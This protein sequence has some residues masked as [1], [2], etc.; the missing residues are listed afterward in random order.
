[1]AI[2]QTITAL[3]TAPARTQSSADFITNADAFVAALGTMVTQENTWAGQV[4]TV[5]GE[6]NNNAVSA[7]ADA[8]S[9]AASAST[10][11][12]VAG[13]VAWVSGTTYALNDAAISQIDFQT[14]RRII[15]GAGTTDPSADATNWTLLGG[16]SSGLKS[17]TTTVAVS[18]ATAPSTGQVLTAISST[19]ATWQNA[20]GA[21]VYLST[22]TASAA[23]TVDFTSAMSATYDD[24]IMIANCTSSPQSMLQ[25]VVSINN[26][27]TWMTTAGDYISASQLITDSVF[28]AATINATASF[29]VLGYAQV[30]ST[31]L[32]FRIYGVNTGAQK[33]ILSDSLG[34]TTTFASNTHCYGVAK[35]AS[36]INAVRIR[37]ASGTITGTF[38][39]Y[40]IAKA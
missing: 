6:V 8:V 15:A 23:A 22:V 33:N 38:K 32:E 25:M 11:A 29:L 24:Y 7:A 5:A 21:L 30:T 36:A 9:A 28:Q 12:S 2:T 14:Y 39:L 18:T 26:G 31:S 4:N 20:A 19:K 10:A 35:T 1:M 34:A 16:V 3:P 17:A 13:A 40:G 27:S 37:P